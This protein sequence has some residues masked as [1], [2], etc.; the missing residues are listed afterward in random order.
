MYLDF[1]FLAL[2]G[3]GLSCHFSITEACNCFICVAAGI[4]FRVEGL[5]FFFCFIVNVLYLI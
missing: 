4:D 3:R 2:H 1:E 5:L